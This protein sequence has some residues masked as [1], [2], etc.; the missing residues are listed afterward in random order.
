MRLQYR[1]DI[2]GLR[3]LAVTA[4]V[5][6][7]SEI[8][9]FGEK[10]FNGGFIGVDIFFVISGYLISG[11]ILSELHFS[12]N[13][14][15][16]HFIEK[17]ARRLL[18]ALFTFILVS[19][20]FAFYNLSQIYFDEFIDSVYSA[21]T[22][23][24]N[25]YYHY[26]SEYFDA[27]YNLKPLL[28]T[29]S[30]SIEIQFYFFFPLLIILFW[31]KIKLLLL[32]LSILILFNILLVQ[33]GGNLTIHY[34]FV[35]PEFVFFNP[36]VLGTFFWTTSR[37]WEFIFGALIFILSTKYKIRSN[38]FVSTFGLLLIFFSFFIFYLDV[39]NPSL[40]TLLPIIGTSLI[41]IESKKENIVINILQNRYLVFIGLISY[42]TYLFHFLIFSFY[43][44]LMIDNIK[45]DFYIKIFLIILSYI[46]GYIS[47][48]FIEI[49][50]RRKNFKAFNYFYY[51]IFIICSLILIFGYFLNEIKKTSA[52]NIYLNYPN[53]NFE[54]LPL[55]YKKDF[56]LK[57][58]S[59]KNKRRFLIIGDS[60]AYDF[61]NILE[62]NTKLNNEN[63]FKYL[64]HEIYNYFKNIKEIERQAIFKESE[65]I[66][67]TS[68]YTQKDIILLEKV[69]N[70]LKSKNK[71]IILSSH[72]ADY[73][74]IEVPLVD[75]LLSAKKILN[76]VEMEKRLFLSL[77]QRKI[78]ES[79]KIKHIADKNEVIYLNKLKYACN[80]P[81]K[82]CFTTDK[83]NNLINYDKT[84]IGIDG[85]K[86]FGESF[87]IENFFKELKF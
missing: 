22:F 20:P 37:I 31:R 25:I 45:N 59:S 85:A 6:F 57:S 65:F 68:D 80:L 87:Y 35:E 13:F 78:K 3:A 69:I 76:K 66:I 63:E 51:F 26:N 44:G 34:P 2:D 64:E 40:I 75:I 61:Y 1:P 28:H 16:F 67:L 79:K 42:S 23:I 19:I 56:E 39:N 53:I 32:I 72:T 24:S 83:N 86:F 84:H 9:I 30:L 49:P 82:I 77:N 81:K 50:F 27:P 46:L 17:R 36:P 52:S 70:N 21:I 55:E 33:F 47:F 4:V 48:R 60:H 8:L 5:L 29:W 71:K 41:L 18:P 73:N 38:A 58:F 62:S 43:E 7:H 11:I 14:K 74:V 10:V 15:F 12:N 54:I